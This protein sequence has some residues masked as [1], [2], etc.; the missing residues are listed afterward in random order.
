MTIRPVI[1]ET[2]VPIFELHLAHR[3]SV[4]KVPP[5]SKEHLLFIFYEVMIIGK[6][7]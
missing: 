3:A 4:L 6:I 5:V 7:F 1:H 2:Y